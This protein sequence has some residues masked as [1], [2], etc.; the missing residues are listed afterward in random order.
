MPKPVTPMVGCD[1]FI[2]NE[3][4]EVL[5]I[6]RRDSGLWALPGGFHDLG[7]TP[8]KCAVRECFEETGYEITIA[9][10]LGVFSSNNY[11]YV[12]YQWKENEIT[13]ILFIGKIT[14]GE[15]K[16]SDETLQIGWFSEKNL[17]TLFDGHE[18]RI[19]VGFS[20]LN[21]SSRPAHFE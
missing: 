7:E 15:P 16:V 6:K 10:L 19:K 11:K 3:K 2:T 20:F 18:A 17:P 1:S 21:D 14:G 9:H 12:N 13:H 4:K 8:A 5:L